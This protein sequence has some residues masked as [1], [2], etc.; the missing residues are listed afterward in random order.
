FIKIASIF[1]PDSNEFFDYVKKSHKSSSKK[2]KPNP[3]NTL[4]Q[5]TRPESNTLDE[6]LHLHISAL[7]LKAKKS[8]ISSACYAHKTLLKHLE[9]KHLALYTPYDIE[10]AISKM[11]QSL[12]PKSIL[13]ALSYANSAFK[14]AQKQGVITQN[15]V[16][17]AKKPKATS[18]S[19]NIFSLSTIKKLLTHAT[20]ELKTFL[21]I[22][23]FTGARCGEILALSKADIDF[24]TDNLSIN[25]NQ[26]RF[27]LTTPKNGKS[28][29]IYLLKP[30]KTYLLSLN[31]PDDKLF[32]MDY[33]K[34]YYE[35]KKL[36][37]KLNLAPSGLHST[38][39]TFASILL[40]KRVNSPLIAK[41]LGHSSTGL[42]ERT[43][44]HFL[45]D[46]NDLKMLN[47]AFK[48]TA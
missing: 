22:A 29:D 6:F 25:K 45:K 1:S 3:K 28:R 48:Q 46:K 14:L 8:T 36:L 38:R 37:K 11:S 31:L 21:Y 39:H 23:F 33:F 27:E 41:M 26:T 42:V 43:Y 16:E 10:N 35:Y 9:N 7:K 19:K 12:A 20:G 13:S 24:K 5:S 15:P 4:K 17:F 34:I 2:A 18:T 40:Q 32:T 30:L 44:G 47:S